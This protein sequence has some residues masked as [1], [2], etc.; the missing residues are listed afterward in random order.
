MVRRAEDKAG[1]LGADVRAEV[2]ADDR[3]V[4]ERVTLR[5]AYCEALSA[6]L[7]EELGVAKEKQEWIE[8]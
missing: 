4:P 2:T 8:G 7:A 6:W 3:G 1:Q 5:G